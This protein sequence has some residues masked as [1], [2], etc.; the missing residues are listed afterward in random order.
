MTARDPFDTLSPEFTV[1]V[2]GK[3]LPN[4]AKADLIAVSVLDDVDAPGMF[5][6]TLAGWDT[7]TMQPK[8]IDDPLFDLGK[9]VEIA[10]GYRDRTQTLLSGDITGLEPD[11]VPSR[12]PALTVRGYDGRHRL[13]RSRRT[14][15]FTNCKDSDIVS[16]IAGEAQLNPKVD[17]SGVQLPYVLQHNQT[18]LEFLMSRAHRIDFEL[19][20]QGTDLLFRKRA[21]GDTPA[22]T[23]HR[24]VELLEFRARLS[25]LG[26][27]PALEVRGWDPAQ[28]KEIVGRA[29]GG[30]QT[31]GGG[32]LGPAATKQAF[33]PPDAARV[34]APVQSQDEA[35]AMARQG[36]AGMAL[37]YVRADGVC[38]GEPRLRAGMVVAIEGIGTRFSGNWYVTSVEHAFTPRQGFRTSFSARRNAS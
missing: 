4:E 23:L 32:T 10:L 24:E 19:A 31:M 21:F 18:D 37:G 26:Q 28:K 33:S 7:R 29:T 38:I 22:L 11:F 2:G 35:D 12:P 16:R 9:P 34:D 5:A 1:S 27:V 36:F 30:P 25:T 15:S 3:P 17:D 20:V 6:I 14:R 8:W 13:T